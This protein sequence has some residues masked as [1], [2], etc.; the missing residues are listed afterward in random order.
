MTLK[1]NM[2]HT[3]SCC[4]CDSHST[5][6]W[7]V[8]MSSNDEAQSG[9]YK[10]I[11]DNEKIYTILRCDKHNYDVPKTAISFEFIPGPTIGL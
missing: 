1:I 10:Q 7:N 5:R 4:K 6:R 3:Y 11:G 9:I 2:G 8:T